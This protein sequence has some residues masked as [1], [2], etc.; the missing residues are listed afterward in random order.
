MQ[1]EAEIM[2]GKVQ[3]TEGSRHR[4]RSLQPCRAARADRVEAS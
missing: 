2:Q 4:H 1:Q 3:E